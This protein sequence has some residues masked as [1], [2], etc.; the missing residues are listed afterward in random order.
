MRPSEVSAI[1]TSL[2]CLVFVVW[3]LQSPLLFPIH[4][5]HRTLVVYCGDCMIAWC[6]VVW[7]SVDWVHWQ[8]HTKKEGMFV[9]C[10]VDCGML[11]VSEWERGKKSGGVVD[12]KWWRDGVKDT[13]TQKAKRCSFPSNTFPPFF[14]LLFP[15]LSFPDS[16]LLYHYPQS[17]AHSTSV[18]F[19]RHTCASTMN[20]TPNNTTPN[21]ILLYFTHVQFIIPH[22]FLR[23]VVFS[24]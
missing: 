17:M 20:E 2:W 15:F 7:L 18:F 19:V 22:I 24:W 6:C 11:W 21:S 13:V 5:V 1:I 12:W 16:L 4:S 8:L 9:L 3:C 23:Y 10:G 14:S